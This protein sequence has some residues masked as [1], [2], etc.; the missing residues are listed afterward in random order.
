MGR[1]THFE[2]ESQ[3]LHLISNWNL[4]LKWKPSTHY[5][6][7]LLYWLSIQVHYPEW[8]SL[9]VLQWDVCRHFVDS[10]VCCIR[11]ALSAKP[12]LTVCLFFFPYKL[13][14]E[15][16]ERTN[17]KLIRGVTVDDHHLRPL[18]VIITNRWKFLWHRCIFV[19]WYRVSVV[20]GNNISMHKETLFWLY[21]HASQQQITCSFFLLGV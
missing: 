13:T 14:Q 12:Q 11:S 16:L 18:P 10:L 8:M 6:N 2:S 1:T 17:R 20:N 21:S 15:V 4:S 9:L 5:D 19:F 3:R 7:T